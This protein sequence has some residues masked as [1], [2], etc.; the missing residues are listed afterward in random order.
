MTTHDPLGDGSQEPRPGSA[1]IYP[2]ATATQPT[3]PPTKKPAGLALAALIVGIVA[4]LFGLIPV[5]GALVGVVAVV[6]G[7]IAIRK[8]QSKGKA[9]TGVILGGIA[10]L[11]SISM[12]IGSMALVNSASDVQPVP[13]TAETAT[14]EPVELAEAVTP[15]PVEETKAPEP[16]APAVPAEFKSALTSAGSYAKMMDMSKAGIYDQLTSEYGGQFTAE[17]GQYAIDNVEADWAANALASAKTYQEQMAM[18]PAAIHDQLTSEYGGQF[19]VE[20]ADY[21]IAHLND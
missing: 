2:T 11:A 6:L 19:T 15:E 20:E 7:I 1:P 21:A 10:I 5:F 13:L 17:A 12:T 3:P 9:L 16:E 18:S 8:R 4:F 14:A